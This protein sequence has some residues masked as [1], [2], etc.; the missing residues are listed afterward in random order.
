MSETRATAPGFRA[1]VLREWRTLA[2]STSLQ[3]MHL[4][5]PMAVLLLL[6]LVFS[7]G[8]LRDLPVVVVDRDNSAASR[9]LIEWLDASPGL[10]VV[11]TVERLADG[12]ASVRRLESYALVFVPED[13]QHDLLR[14]TNVTVTGFYN[15][16]LSSVGSTINREIRAAVGSFGSRYSAG[17]TLASGV[18]ARLVAAA[19]QPI[20]MQGAPLF[21]PEQSY[22]VFL[23]AAFVPTVMQLFILLTTIWTIGSELRNRSAGHWLDL[24]GGNIAVA[25]LGKLAVYF[26]LHALVLMAATFGVHG[27]FGWSSPHDGVALILAQLAYVL[28][29]QSLGLL[30]VAL[31][32]GLRGAL[33]VGSLLA[34]P[35]FGFSGVSLPAYTMNGFASFIH[36]LLPLS[37]Y[38]ELY[39]GQAFRGAGFQP[40]LSG[41]GA[42]ALFVAAG[43]GLGLPRLRRLC[44]DPEKWG[45]E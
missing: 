27:W 20:A 30:L 18:P 16:Q 17:R 28:A 1:V 43:F 22:A 6:W 29:C 26:P 31:L 13:F 2:S 23:F 38:I 44:L 24:A 10:R 25:V 11:R 34:G 4:F 32:A 40:W 42:M 36:R 7:Q 9:Q 12:E 19:I 21:N 39:H 15:A 14:R 45:A 3:V 37:S 33:S 35:A 8:V 5:G 41:M